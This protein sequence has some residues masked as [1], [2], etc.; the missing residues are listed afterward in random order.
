MLFPFCKVLLLAA[1]RD[2]KYSYRRVKATTR[3]DEFARRPTNGQS[4]LALCKV[5][6]FADA[7]MAQRIRI[8]SRE[9]EQIQPD[10]YRSACRYQR[11]TAGQRGAPFGAD[12]GKQIGI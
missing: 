7:G 8:K 10:L 11:R 1:C 2:T 3:T 4:A 6:A 5:Q 9:H 12:I